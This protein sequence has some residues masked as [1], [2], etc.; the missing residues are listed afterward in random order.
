VT[1]AKNQ[2][3]IGANT[4]K[5]FHLWMVMKGKLVSRIEN[6]KTEVFS[7]I[8]DVEITQPPQGAYSEDIIADCE[9][10]IAEC[11]REE[12]EHCIGGFFEQ[13]TSNNEAHSILK[14]VELLRGMPPDRFQ[15]LILALQINEFRD[16]EVIVQQNNPGDCFYIIKSGKVDVFK[17]GHNVRT[18]TKHDYFGERSVLFNQFRSATVVANGEVTCWVLRQRDFLSI[19]DENIRTHLEKRIELQDDHITL[20]DLIIVKLLGK[21]MFGNVF[22]A[23]H[24]NKKCLYA[25]KTVHRQKIERFE[26]QENL[27]L[28]RKILLQLDHTLILKLVATFKDSARIYF[29][30]EFVRGMDLFDVL[31]QLNL[32]TDKDAKF[33]VACLIIILEYLHERDIIYR[34]LKPENVMIDEDGYPKLID[35]GTAKIVHGRTYTIVGTPHY[36]APEVIVGKGYSVAVDY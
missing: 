23:A 2:I 10:I 16:Q 17:D 20:D 5:G 26:I 28:E 30:T 15:A 22:L 34:D 33:Y 35:F 9:S 27:V 24:K 36:M 13:V 7:C 25:L 21:G 12:F 31:R 8:G 29:L 14:R 19:I 32:V 4:H 6:K 11:T 18:I 1:Y 3:V